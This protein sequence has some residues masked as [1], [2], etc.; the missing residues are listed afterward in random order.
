MLFAE[1]LL[2]YAV[3]QRTM[4]IFLYECGYH[5]KRGR[6]TRNL[7]D[8]ISSTLNFRTMKCT[9]SYVIIMA[10]SISS[11]IVKKSNRIRHCTSYPNVTT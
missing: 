6:K 7:I 11:G 1:N 5:H 9:I 3:C 4:N 8:I 2:A 10:L